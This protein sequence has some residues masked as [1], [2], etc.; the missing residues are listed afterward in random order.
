MNPKLNLAIWR[1]VKQKR[2]FLLQRNNI[3]Q[4]AF[5][6]RTYCWHWCTGE[7]WMQSVHSL[8]RSISFGGHVF[9]K[10]K[11]QNNPLTFRQG[12]G[13]V[14]KGLEKGIQG[15]KVRGEWEITI[16]PNQGYSKK[17]VEMSSHKIWLLSFLYSLLQLGVRHH[18]IHHCN[19]KILDSKLCCNAMCI[20]IDSHQSWMNNFRSAKI[21][22]YTKW[23]LRWCYSLFRA[24]QCLRNYFFITLNSFHHGMS[25]CKAN[26]DAAEN[27]IHVRVQMTPNMI[28]INGS[29]KHP[30]KKAN[31]S[32]FH[33][34]QN[35]LGILLVT[36]QV[37]KFSK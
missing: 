35:I 25:V 1:K 5:L 32:L 19:Y 22:L 24:H 11:N 26:K 34:G 10:N 36:C 6:S 13:K 29:W 30:S 33:H 20:V 37:G 7:T 31:H 16:P 2:L 27:D 8:W 18:C 17:E 21:A 3:C 23:L 4:V 12:T 28:E 15:M 14:I 9:D